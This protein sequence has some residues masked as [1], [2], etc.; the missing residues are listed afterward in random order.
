MTP[1]VDEPANLGSYL[2]DVQA[3]L[4]DFDGP[5]CNVFAG[6]SAGV[7]AGQLRGVLA[8]GGWHDLPEHVCESQ[9]PFT[10]LMYAAQISARDA[11][12][13]ESAFAAH[14]VEAVQF[15]NP[16][17]G[18]HDFVKL[19]AESGRTLAVVSNN[20]QQAVSAYLH[21]HKID[22]YVTHVSA[23]TGPDM[24]KLKPNPFLLEQALNLLG[25][26]SEDAGIIG[27]STTDMQAGR[28]AGILCVGYAN[29][30]EKLVTLR[31]FAHVIT[32]TMEIT[33]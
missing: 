1:S 6:L 15:A 28:S 11:A 27:D 32:S 24:A 25:C 23:R 20:S 33:F 31:P 26:R 18:A 7:V 9:D 16:T 13:V 12:Y 29:K 21:M 19:W 17:R 8:D 2:K 3:L 30:P 10:V 14:E 22:K 5:I 4:L